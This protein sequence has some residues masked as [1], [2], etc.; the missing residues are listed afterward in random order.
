MRLL[1][2]F[3]VLGL[4]LGTAAA[5]PIIETP[6][7]IPPDLPL[8]TLTQDFGVGIKA[9]F[10]R[11]RAR[12]LRSRT[13]NRIISGL[14]SRAPPPPAP[15]W[16]SI[17]PEDAII[18]S[19]ALRSSEQLGKRSNT[20]SCTSPSHTP[21]KRQDRALAMADPEA[22]RWAGNGVRGRVLICPLLDCFARKSREE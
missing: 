8:P 12:I 16:A 22:I 11:I 15:A 9:F 21:A 3:L 5:A 4:L 7:S 1:P 19:P 14:A 6:A 17:P 10:R 2:V 18:S 20:P 13:S